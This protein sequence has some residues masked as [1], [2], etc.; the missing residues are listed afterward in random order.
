MLDKPRVSVIIPAYNVAQYIG[1]AIDSALRQTYPIAEIIIIDD[2]S[3]DN[4]YELV[5]GSYPQS[6]IFLFRHS[7]RGPSIARNIAA[8][9]ATGSILAFLDADDL[10]LPEKLEKQLPL[11]T[12]PAV[13][14]VY[15][16]ADFLG[17]SI[18][19]Q[20]TF[21]SVNP[22]AHGR[23][24]R[25]LLKRNFVP[26]LTAM[27]RTELFHELGGFDVNFRAAEDYD[28]WLRASFISS[29]TYV[30]DTIAR[31]RIHPAAATQQSAQM[32][33]S[34]LMALWKIWK[35]PP[36]ILDTVSRTLLANRLATLSEKILIYNPPFAKKVFWAVWHHTTPLAWPRRFFYFLKKPSA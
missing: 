12:D 17:S 34:E 23:V 5:R 25:Q 6:N 2:G 11:F 15:G 18:E 35:H 26:M 20:K 36:Q 28:L 13:G 24:T 16:N 31:Y 1:T 7:N 30:N 33:E 29:F 10:W 4:T 32:W 9:H 8:A 27:I 3:T 19:G 22:P 21:F 14:V